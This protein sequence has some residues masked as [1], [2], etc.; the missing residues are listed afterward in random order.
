MQFFTRILP[1]K[2]IFECFNFTKT[3]SILYQFYSVYK[4]KHICASF[5]K[6]HPSKLG[7]KC[8]SQNRFSQVYT[9]QYHQ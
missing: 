9:H 4:L 5:C 6:W 3:S 8:K 1:V 7:L 2:L